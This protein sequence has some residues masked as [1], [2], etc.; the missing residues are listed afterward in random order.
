MSL[1]L[2]NPYFNKGSGAD[3]EQVYIFI[4]NVL[5]L[6]WELEIPVFMLNI[7]SASMFYHES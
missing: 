2:R 7:T 3:K 1:T 4:T 6:F 5:D